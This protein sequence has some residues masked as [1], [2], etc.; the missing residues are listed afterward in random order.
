MVRVVPLF[1]VFLIW[2]ALEVAN[3][4]L[5]M[6]D[7]LYLPT[8]NVKKQEVI[9]K[10]CLFLCIVSADVYLIYHNLLLVALIFSPLMLVKSAMLLSSFFEVHMQQVAFVVFFVVLVSFVGLNV[11]LITSFLPWPSGQI[12]AYLCEVAGELI[13]FGLLSILL[14]LRRKQL[15][16]FWV[17]KLSTFD[18]LLFALI[19]YTAGTW[20]AGIFGN[21][22]QTDPTLKLLF[23]VMITSIVVM[24]VRTVIIFEHKRTLETING[25]LEDQVKQSTEYYQQLMEQE[26]QTKKFRHDTM[27][28]LLGLHGLIQ[29]GKQE[30]ALAYIEELE[31]NLDQ[32]RP[33]Y[34]TGNFIADAILSSKDTKASKVQTRIDF[35]GKI[36]EK[37]VRDVDMVIIFSNILDNAIEACEQLEGEKCIRI[38]SMIR[39]SMWAMEVSNPCR[40]IKIMNNQVA[41]TKAEK[42]LHGFGLA[43][44]RRCVEKYDGNLQ[45]S[46]DGGRFRTM[47]SFLIQ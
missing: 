22:I 32:L 20:E 26:H 36:P 28:L 18:L 25:L 29:E 13:V 23:G 45:I 2:S 21:K 11:S 38:Q 35:E 1:I 24:I 9:G 34:H 39:K 10:G 6:R 17:S 30:Q 19:L 46:C 7:F 41:T 15:M 8:K 3:V 40:E 43:N 31:G 33:K 47:V 4:T 5:L 44:I 27:N 12:G 16:I 14:V 37:L 42:D